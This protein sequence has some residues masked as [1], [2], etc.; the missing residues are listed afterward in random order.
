MNIFRRSSHICSEFELDVTKL[1]FTIFLLI[2]SL[3][4]KTI[5]VGKAAIAFS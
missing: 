2:T 4:F 5:S 3:L 1:N